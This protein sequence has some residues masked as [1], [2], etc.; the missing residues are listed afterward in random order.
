MPKY[1]DMEYDW[2]LVTGE[3]TIET[4]DMKI[5]L[6]KDF[7]N[8]LY[9]N[10]DQRFKKVMN[11]LVSLSEEYE[12]VGIGESFGQYL[13]EFDRVFNDLLRIL[14]SPQLVLD[15]IPSSN[16][17]ENVQVLLEEPDVILIKILEPKSTVTMTTPDTGITLTASKTNM[18]LTTEPVTMSVDVTIEQNATTT[19]TI[20]I[21]TIL[22]EIL[23]DKL[24]NNT[25]LEMAK[26]FKNWF[27]FI[28]QTEPGILRPVFNLQ[29]TMYDFILF[30]L[31]VILYM[32]DFVYFV[33]K[34]I[35]ACR[36]KTTPVHARS[37]TTK[38]MSPPKV[39]MIRVPTYQIRKAM[40]RKR[41]E[42]IL[43]TLMKSAAK[44]KEPVPKKRRYIDFT[45]D[46]PLHQSDSFLEI[47]EC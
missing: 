14:A 43:P 20:S 30:V 2:A 17:K 19:P 32:I 12:V 22:M 13:E 11:K 35:K 39:N 4:P 38:N 44:P 23:T 5:N 34:C 9:K 10:K 7:I 18:I 15:T 16:K 8:R 28:S 3:N 25:K 45:Q 46:I 6:T 24:S 1:T 31:I 42:V 40:R 27:S 33:V 36:K 41:E 37:I 29:I 21:S 26:R 47:N